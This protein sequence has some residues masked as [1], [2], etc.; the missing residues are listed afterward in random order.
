MTRGVSGAGAPLPNSIAPAQ[1][2]LIMG[3]VTYAYTPLVIGE[4]VETV[5]LHDTIC[6][7]LRQW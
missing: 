1:T 4:A 7:A 6:L 5:T 2:P 3:T